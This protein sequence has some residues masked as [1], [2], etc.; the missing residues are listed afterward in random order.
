M[1]DD[2]K[3]VLQPPSTVISQEGGQ[4][5][6]PRLYKLP[7]N[8]LL[9]VCKKDGDYPFSRNLTFRSTD[10]GLNWQVEYFNDDLIP[11]GGIAILDE[12]RVRLYGESVIVKWSRP[13][14]A[15]YFHSESEDGGRTFGK[16]GKISYELPGV[17][18]IH[19]G[20]PLGKCWGLIDKIIYRRDLL[21]AA[22][23]TQPEFLESA[24][25]SL[26]VIGCQQSCLTLGDGKLLNFKSACITPKKSNC[27]NREYSLLANISHDN[28]LHWEHHSVVAEYRPGNFPF[29]GG[30]LAQDLPPWEHGYFEA[31]A[32]LLD[33]G[34]IYLVMRCGGGGVP[35]AHCWSSDRGK[36]WTKATMIDRRICGVAPKVIKLSDGSLALG[37]GRPGIFVDFDHSGTG[38]H[39]NLDSRIDIAS[40][41]L[42]TLNANVRPMVNRINCYK[43]S[44]HI[45]VPLHMADYVRPEILESFYYSWENV[46]IVELSPGRILATYDLQNLIDNTGHVPANAIRCSLITR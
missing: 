17:E 39:W 37:H 9:I 29:D 10:N 33:D 24:R 22:G 4:M 46:D 26:P 20:E 35:L 30:K 38:E 11:A 7:C 14:H 12:K 18:R 5:V 13:E 27:D 23:W 45:N 41:E 43:I 42:E 21:E 16:V 6:C 1:S 19:Q 31:S 34:R 44:D 3:W 28:G 25:L 2:N 15:L 36:T 8:D 32:V 40:G